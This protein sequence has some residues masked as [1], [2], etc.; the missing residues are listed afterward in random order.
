[1]ILTEIIL[2]NIFAQYEPE[3]VVAL[4]SSFIFHEKTDIEPVLTER[5]QEGRA[6]ILAIAD[7][8][9]AVQTSYKDDSA[10]LPESTLRFG[11]AEVVYEWARGMPFS[12]ITSLTDVQEGTIVRAITRLDD[13]C[14]EVKDA[15]RIVGNAELFRK[16]E[17]CQEKI[18][19]DV[20]FCASLYF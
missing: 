18:R 2:E 6:T 7:K 8:V 4:L 16:M 14:R 3:E 5:L 17:E 9:V 20:V 13:T 1:L 19:R 10:E 12:Q 11:L 15:A